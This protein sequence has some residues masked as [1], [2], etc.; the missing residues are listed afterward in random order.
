MF[1]PYYARDGTRNDVKFIAFVN[2][3]VN[4]RTDPDIETGFLFDSAKLKKSNI[5]HNLDKKLK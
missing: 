4:K 3:N 2:V 5:M 1:K